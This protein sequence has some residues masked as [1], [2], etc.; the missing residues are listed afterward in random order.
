MSAKPDNRPWW[1]VV[2]YVLCW[3]CQREH[4]VKG[5]T[6]DACRR[7]ATRAGWFIDDNEWHEK[8]E[9]SILATCPDCVTEIDDEEEE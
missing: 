2:I 1:P 6:R 3:K 7:S 8:T 4:T 9:H 5:H